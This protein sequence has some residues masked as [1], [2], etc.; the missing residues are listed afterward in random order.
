MNNRK[1]DEWTVD[2]WRLQPPALQLDESPLVEQSP[3]LWKDLTLA[4]VVA[5][6]LWILAVAILR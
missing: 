2:R 5:L 3:P 6:L 4:S 1:V